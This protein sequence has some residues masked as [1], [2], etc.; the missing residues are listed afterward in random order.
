M[1]VKYRAC[2]AH[3]VLQSTSVLEGSTIVSAFSIDVNF[4]WNVH[5]QYLGEIYLSVRI[6][7]WSSSL[8]Y[9]STTVECA[10]YIYP[11][12]SNKITP[13]DYTNMAMDLLIVIIITDYCFLNFKDQVHERI[14]LKKNTLWQ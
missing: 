11:H 7:I 8:A 3:F 13:L 12:I 2:C 5:S 14:N 4:F 10:I 1:C 6:K 9:L